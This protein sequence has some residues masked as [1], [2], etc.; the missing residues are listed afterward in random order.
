MI[1]LQRPDS[2]VSALMGENKGIHNGDVVRPSIFAIPFV[3]GKRK[4]VLNTLTRECIE[5]ECFSWFENPCEHIYDES[6][7]EM[8]NL[9]AADFLVARE[10]DEIKKYIGMLAFLRRMETPKPGYVGY[11]ILPT[12]AC[13]AR[14][15]YCYELG[16]KYETM[17]DEVVEQT[18]RYIRATK[19][20]NS[21]IS[22]HWFGGEP[23]LGEKIIDRICGAL[24]EE[25]I[26]YTSNMIS[27][28][29][30]MTEEL[31]E[32]ARQD[33]HMNSVQITL[34]GREEVYCERKKY[35][36]FE[37]SPYRAVLNGIH[38][39]LDQKIIVSVRLNADEQNLD[40]LIALVDELESEFEKE[41][42]VNVYCHSIFA[43]EDYS[44]RDN[45]E[46]YSGMEILNERIAKFNNNR[47]ANSDKEEENFHKVNDAAEIS[48]ENDEDRCFEDEE[49]KTEYYDRR[50]YLRRYY[51]MVDNPAAGPVILPSGK[52]NLC[53]HIDTF[54]I[55]GTIFDE[56]TIDLESYFETNRAEI[57]KCSHCGLLPVCTDFISCPTIARDCY[58]ENLA[59]EKYSLRPLENE[60]RLP[61]VAVKIDG[62]IIRVTEPNEEFIR[63]YRKLMVPT[64]VKSEETLACYDA[65]QLLQ[66]VNRAQ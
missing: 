62:K 66:R 50:G 30:L 29:S 22:L 58:K 33:W 10:Y 6:E 27:N 48:W 1:T 60:D 57:K 8:K 5:T 35:H 45:D 63:T 49:M 14:C 3:L 59:I 21:T 41:S 31:A 40:E 12:T 28:G 47:R 34:D 7:T 17:N 61:P 38:A 13:N 52:L 36:A 32:K 26:Q 16:M 15:V 53:E 39:L 9:V 24:R 42:L 44:D 56:R 18:I 25:D 4:V 19:R 46:L 43:E 64:Y 54:P 23:L 20:E 37:G 11:T 55:V 2:K 65:V 51:C